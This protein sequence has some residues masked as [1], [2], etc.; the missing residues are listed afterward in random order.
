MIRQRAVLRRFSFVICVGLLANAGSELA[1][2]DELKIQD[3]DALRSILKQAVDAR[4]V[5]GVSLLIAHKGQVVF[6][7]AVGDLTVDRQIMMASCAKPVTATLVMILVDQ[8]KLKLDDPIEKYL[9]EFKGVMIH[10]RAPKRPPTVR[11]ILSNTS[12]LPGDP[13]FLMLRDRLRAQAKESGG[14]ASKML[15]ELDAKVEQEKATRPRARFGF[16]GKRTSSLAD[17]VR[18]LAEG[19]LESEP[20]EEFHYCTMGFNVAARVAEVAGGKPFEELVQAELFEPLG[21]K[22]TRFTP[23]GAGVFGGPR[24]K[25]GESRFIIAGGGMVSTL[26]DFAAFYEMFSAG[27]IYRGQRIL[28]LESVNTMCTRQTSLN[29]RLGSATPVGA[30]YGLAF[31]LSRLDDQQRAHVIT[32]PGLFGA[33]PWLDLD[34]ELVGVLFV[35]SNFMRVIPLVQAIQARARAIFPASKPK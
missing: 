14:D 3:R 8:N 13:I 17:S 9:P 24:L 4:T 20:G 29:L 10:G 18:A 27:G 30:D 19:G 28:S 22:K 16:I 31:F 23:L 5:P 34:R 15:K 6:K 32:H 33:T 25:N 21:M 2:G 35:Q 11:Q 26:D 7:E 1:A 12:G